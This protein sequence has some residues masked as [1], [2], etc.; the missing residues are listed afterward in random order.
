LREFAQIL[1]LC[2]IPRL[3]PWA[4]LL[5]LANYKFAFSLKQ[6]SLKGCLYFHTDYKNL[7]RSI[8][9][10]YPTVETVGNIL[11]FSQL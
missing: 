10:Q 5:N 3:K 7:S 4:I 2:N 11:K 6:F 8:S 9:L 1:S